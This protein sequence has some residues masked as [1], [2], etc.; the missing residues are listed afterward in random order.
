MGGR[1]GRGADLD[2]L[3]ASREWGGVTKGSKV[4]TRDGATEGGRTRMHGGQLAIKVCY[5]RQ[6]GDA[7][8]GLWEEPRECGRHGRSGEASVPGIAAG[9]GPGSKELGGEGGEG[10]CGGGGRVE[11]HGRLERG[12]DNGWRMARSFYKKEVSERI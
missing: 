11:S 9:G 12:G 6:G 3:D 8:A 5:R 1:V 2:Q 10:E 7:R 4:R